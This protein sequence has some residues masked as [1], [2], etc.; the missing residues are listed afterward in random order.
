MQ[1]VTRATGSVYFPVRAVRASVSNSSR[2]P[3]YGPGLELD[4]M[5]RSEL[6]TGKQGY[7][8]GLG[9]G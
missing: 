5:V 6:L 7:P 2:L 4:R 3:G 8:P 9:T 1:R